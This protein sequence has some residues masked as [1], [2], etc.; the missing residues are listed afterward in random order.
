MG[1]KDINSITQQMNNTTLDN[2]QSN[3]NNDNNERN[4]L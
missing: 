3:I 4:L 2:V 1:N